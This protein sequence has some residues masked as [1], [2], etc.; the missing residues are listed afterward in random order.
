MKF[1]SAL[2]KWKMTLNEDKTVREAKKITVLGYEVENRKISPDKVWRQINTE[3]SKVKLNYATYVLSVV[4]GIALLLE[5][6]AALFFAI[7]ALLKD[8]KRRNKKKN[9]KNHYFVSG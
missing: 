3:C 8:R 6:L 4:F 5:L 9:M 2:K 7:K 1:E